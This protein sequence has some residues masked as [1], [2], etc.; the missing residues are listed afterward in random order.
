MAEWVQDGGAAMHGPVWLLPPLVDTGCNAARHLAFLL[1]P[2]PGLAR[3]AWRC[4]GLQELAVGSY[5]KVEDCGALVTL[6]SCRWTFNLRWQCLGLADML[7]W[8]NT[9]ARDTRR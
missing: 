9:S 7:L 8:W 5:G 3:S 1:P 4:P 6:P 2:T